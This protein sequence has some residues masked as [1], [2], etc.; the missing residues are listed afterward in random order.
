MKDL[1]DYS[2][3]LLKNCKLQSRRS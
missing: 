1:K 3:R 2:R